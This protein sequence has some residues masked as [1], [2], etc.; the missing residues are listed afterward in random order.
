MIT[1]PSFPPSFCFSFSQRWMA[2]PTSLHP[3]PTT[4]TTTTT[5]ASPSSSNPSLAAQQSRPLPRRCPRCLTPHHRTEAK[6]AAGSP[7]FPVCT[8]RAWCP[9]PSAPSWSTSSSWWH[10]SS[11]SSTRWTGCWH[12]SRCRSSTSTTHLSAATPTASPWSHR[13]RPTRKCHQRS[14]SGWGTSWSEPES[15][16]RFLLVWPSTEPRWEDTVFSNNLSLAQLKTLGSFQI[17]SSSDTFRFDYS[18]FNKHHRINIK[19]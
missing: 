4:T 19:L 7:S 9:R 12:S 6:P 8:T 14:I 2:C 11:T 13:W 18:R 15:H 16:R 5:W 17:L 1:D 3:A 10:R